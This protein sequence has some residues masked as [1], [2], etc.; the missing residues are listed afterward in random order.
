MVFELMA[1]SSANPGLTLMKAPANASETLLEPRM[2]PRVISAARSLGSDQVGLARAVSVGRA[3]S[4]EA[5]L[6][7][8]VAFY[9]EGMSTSV[10]HNA[11][12]PDDG[13]R[14]CFAWAFA[15][16]DA[17]YTYRPEAEVGNGGASSASFS[18][19]DMEANLNS[20]HA[21]EPRTVWWDN[22][23]CV[24]DNSDTPHM[25]NGD[26]IVAYVDSHPEVYY[27]CEGPDL[28][29]IADPT[30]FAIQLMLE[31]TTSPA[32]CS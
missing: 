30:G 9:T 23:Y 10:S 12:T 1:N 28:H 31:F 20:A 11:T 13:Q 8:V 17:C 3:V 22:H 32:Q 29:Y 16:S 5:M 7:Q 4:S 2:S 14:V 24:D 15:E 26:G 25:Y 27:S 6:A 18:V 21:T 19:A